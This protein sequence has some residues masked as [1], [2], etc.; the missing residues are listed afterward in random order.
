VS[1]NITVKRIVDRYLEHGRVFIFHNM[2]N[3]RM[4]MGSSD[5]MNRN[6]YSRIEV[7]FPIYDPEIRQEIMDMIKIQLEDTTDGISIFGPQEETAGEVRRSQ[8][9]VSEFL[10]KKYGGN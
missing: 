7:C 5:W 1:E 6:I 9:L 3:T 8:K 4:Y 2:G 10:D